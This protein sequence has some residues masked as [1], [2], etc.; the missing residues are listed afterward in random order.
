MERTKEYFVKRRVKVRK[1]LR[2]LEP[3]VRKLKEELST[4]DKCLDEVKGS[5]K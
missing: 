3:L 5:K 2:N 1:Y 4:L